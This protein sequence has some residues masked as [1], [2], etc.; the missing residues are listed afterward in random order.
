MFHKS[1]Y[2]CSIT[3]SILVVFYSISLDIDCSQILTLTHTKMNCCSWFVPRFPC[4]F[5]EVEADAMHTVLLRV[6]GGGTVRGRGTG[7]CRRQQLSGFREDFPPARCMRPQPRKVGVRQREGQ[8]GRGAEGPL[9][10]SFPSSSAGRG[11]L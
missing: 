8:K 9:T 1:T 6:F 3:F 7:Q 5:L 11:F 2:F 10:S 4:K